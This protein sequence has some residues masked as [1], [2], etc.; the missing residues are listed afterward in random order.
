MNKVFPVSILLIMILSFVCN[1]GIIYFPAQ[2]LAQKA[3]NINNLRTY[4]NPT[5]SMK[6]QYPSDWQLEENKGYSE[7]D[8]TV[9][10]FSSPGSEDVRISVENLDDPSTSLM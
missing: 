8:I 4:D 1:S 10:T 2:V 9:V 5:F 3:N 6:I 7:D